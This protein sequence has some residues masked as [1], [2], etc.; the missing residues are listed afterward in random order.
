MKFTRIHRLLDHGKL[1]RACKCSCV[2]HGSKARIGCAVGIWLELKGRKMRINRPQTQPNS[3]AVKERTPNTNT[4]H[5]KAE[6]RAPAKTFTGGLNFLR[7][8]MITCIV[9]T[10]IDHHSTHSAHKIALNHTFLAFWRI[11]LELATFNPINFLVGISPIF[12]Y[13][14]W[15]NIATNQISLTHIRN[16]IQHYSWRTN[17]LSH[18]FA[19][20]LIRMNKKKTGRDQIDRWYRTFG[21]LDNMALDVLRTFHFVNLYKIL[22]SVCVVRQIRRYDFTFPT[23]PPPKCRNVILGWLFFYFSVFDKY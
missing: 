10:V 22:E 1:V 13:T 6:R 5:S 16:P 11:E 14:T 15:K 17:R 8:S 19:F 21:R 23:L 12:R 4:N 7:L 9:S 18:V 3:I 20:E 2:L